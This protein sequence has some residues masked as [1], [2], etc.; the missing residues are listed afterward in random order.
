MTIKDNIEKEK[1]GK[2]LENEE[3]KRQSIQLIKEDKN[4]NSIG[5]KTVVVY[6]EDKT[7]KLFVQTL[8]NA[9][10]R[11]DNYADS[12]GPTV[13][14][15]VE[16]L[17]KGMRHAYERGVKIKYISE[18]TKHNIN[19]C[20]ELMKIAEVRHVDNAKG[21]MAVSESEYIATAKLQ[22]AKPVSHLIH[23]NVMEIVEQQQYVFKS[24]W[25]N[26]I[27]ATQRIREIEDG[28]ERIETRIL[29]DQDEI[30]DK[31][32]SLC[33]DGEEILICSD[34]GLLKIV[35]DRFFSVYQEIMENYD[36]GYHKGVRWITDLSHRED[37]NV[38]KL[39]MDMGIKIR[40]IRNL[41][42][43]NFLVTDRVFFSNSEKIDHNQ[44]RKNIKQM[45]TTN[46]VLYIN[47]YKLTFEE[48]WKNG[49]DAVDI[50]EDIERGLDTERVDIISRSNNAETAYLDL[51]RSSNKEIMLILPTVNAFL[52]QWK[53]GVF[54]L[55]T[56]AA[57]NRNVKIRMLI[58]SN[59][60]TAKFVEIL[61]KQT[62]S[63]YNTS[64]N[65]SNKVQIRSIQTLT[66]T[67]STILIIDKKVSLV[68]EL[69][70]DSKEKFHEAIGISTYS[71]S[72]AGVLS[73][74]SIFENLWNQTEIYQQ[75]KKSEELQQDFIRITAHELRSPI[76]PI[77]AI[78]EML[79]S[80]VNSKELGNSQQIQ[81]NREEIN[82]YIDAII[83]NAKKLVSL[84]NDI[85]DITRIE[86]NSLTLRKEAVNL[87]L[88]LLEQVME[89]ESQHTG[90]METID[91]H[92]L[93]NCNRYKTRIEY[94]QLNNSRIDDSLLVE[95][96]KSRISQVIYNLLDNAFK[97]TKD[98]DVIH[99]IS[100]VE[101]INDQKCVVI[102]VRDSGKGINMEILPK[103]FTKFTT[104]SEKGI[105]LGLYITKNI[106]EAHSGRIW[107]KNNANGIGATFS[108][109]L[110]CEP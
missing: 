109:T 3:N 19:Y 11:W 82:D 35:H 21:G 49:I 33:K 37:A 56:Q 66:E 84:T 76:Q 104:M 95:L 43:P 81:V 48:L 60:K 90:K 1:T 106:I 12:H 91:L 16:Q 41:P 24:L 69:K 57:V 22:E 9:K 46:D 97:F 8:N 42:T 4:E 80:N 100:D 62:L 55:I 52:R 53:L 68:M 15:G 44:D 28:H 39:F 10:D 50:I 92:T 47:Q 78:S 5:E 51:L 7:T 102:S 85:L 31:I 58:P 32:R 93:T 94:S 20:K 18:I 74:V 34:T 30:N 14:M 83:R 65:D 61:E 26:S 27:P 99:I 64:N 103:L 89:Y 88:F 67:G 72:K 79:K 77:L 98:G 63:I 105:G 75:L 23:S 13:A 38:A 29:D 110:P 54:E 96:D 70:D 45:F 36:K 40:S 6:G 73:Y 25:A 108:F 59:E 71:N 87:R 107:A 17:R 2:K 101:F 86:T